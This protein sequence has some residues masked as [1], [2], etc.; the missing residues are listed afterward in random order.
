MQAAKSL[1]NPI[2]L[3]HGITDTCKV[4]KRM[5]FELRLNGFFIHDIDLVPNNGDEPLDILAKQIDEYCQRSFGDG[6]KFDIVAFSMGGIVSRYYLQR[7]GGLKKV[8]RF[9]TISSPHNGTV[10]AY[11]SFKP[12]C[13]QMRP[14]SEFL[15]DLNSDAKMLDELEFTSIWTPYDLIILPASSSKMPFGREI[16]IPALL[17]PWMLTDKRC[18][19]AVIDTLKLS[20]GVGSRE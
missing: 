4:F 10:A 6:Q 5:A 11:G 1:P 15:Q 12:G 9:I 2:L 19:Q 20:R 18:I 16:I 14:D 13:I 7:L 17:H 8:E 3:V